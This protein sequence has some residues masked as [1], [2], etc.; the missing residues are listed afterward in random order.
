MTLSAIAVFNG[1]AKLIRA[2]KC[3]NGNK[4]IAATIRMA[5]RRR[6]GLIMDLQVVVR[7]TKCQRHRHLIPIIEWRK[8][9]GLA[10]QSR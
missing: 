2:P 10:D 1:V 5:K 9:G 6:A 4:A 3:V 7:V 8:G